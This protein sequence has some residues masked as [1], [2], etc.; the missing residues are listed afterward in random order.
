MKKLF[1]SLCILCVSLCSYSAENKAASLAVQVNLDLAPTIEAVNKV[2]PD[3]EYKLQI[4]VGN[5]V[6]YAGVSSC[7]DA[8]QKAYELLR[9]GADEVTISSVYPTIHSECSGKTYTHS[10]MEDLR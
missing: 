10:N 5:D 2:I 6:A 9:K 1:L 8:K 7:A 4:W 3:A